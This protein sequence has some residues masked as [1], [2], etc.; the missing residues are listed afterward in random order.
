[1]T[2]EK[3][4]VDSEEHVNDLLAIVRD[5]IGKSKDSLFVQMERFD[6]NPNDPFT[7]KNTLLYLN[8]LR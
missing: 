8:S 7:T 2:D 1:M 5:A 6:E 3:S 4:W